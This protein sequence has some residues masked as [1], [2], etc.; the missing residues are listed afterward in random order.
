MPN[1]N[2]SYDKLN[3]KYQTTI[4]DS[5]QIVV[6]DGG[7]LQIPT[8]TWGFICHDE[9][10]LHHKYSYKY[11]VCDSKRYR[12]LR[13]L[14][15]PQNGDHRY[16]FTHLQEV[17]VFYY[18][19]EE[20]VAFEAYIERHQNVLSSR[21]SKVS[22]FNHITTDTERKTEIYKKRLKVG[23]AMNELLKE[24]RNTHRPT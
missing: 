8:P 3:I 11:Y 18:S 1:S 6:L 22:Q 2:T 21:I 17:V 5:Y 23:V 20:R 24:W 16:A 15:D 4:L 9:Y 12:L 13:F 10:T 7:R 19:D 14:Y